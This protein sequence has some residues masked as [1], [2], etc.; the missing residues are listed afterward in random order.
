L[1]A[2]E[3]IE[4]QLNRTPS[5]S[6]LAAEAGCHPVTLARAFRRSFGC[7]IGGYIRRRRLEEAG[8]MLQQTDTPISIVALRTGFS[9]QAH[10]TRALRRASG[11]TPGALRAFKTR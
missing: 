3:L 4:S 2:R 8:R 1:R 11:R 5:L 7:S 6:S 10:L 9:D